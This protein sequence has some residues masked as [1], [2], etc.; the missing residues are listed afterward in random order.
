[1]VK[2][3]YLALKVNAKKKAKMFW[4]NNA[5]YIPFANQVYDIIKEMAKEYE[6]PLI[7]DI[8]G[9]GKAV[10]NL[11]NRVIGIDY[12]AQ[13]IKGDLDNIKS[14]LR[15]NDIHDIDLALLI[16][17][18]QEPLN[19][20]K[21]LKTISNNLSDEGS[22]LITF[23]TAI[24]KPDITQFM[25]SMGKKY[26]VKRLDEYKIVKKL[27][28]YNIKCELNY[29]NYDG[30]INLDNNE[31]FDKFRKSPAS[32]KVINLIE[33]LISVSNNEKNIKAGKEFIDVLK[34][35]SNKV[36]VP[37]KIAV[38]KGKKKILNIN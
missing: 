34:G 12:R 33:K 2:M 5:N 38:I 31:N 16:N 17:V 36:T 18:L 3:I 35:K 30:K 28:K 25:E 4:E 27:E 29:I 11:S 9:D 10:R 1:M 20:Y 37:G 19:H 26:Y 21:L 8:G 14:I 23:P 22:V 32:Q 24:D 13:I 15:E 6:N 7:A